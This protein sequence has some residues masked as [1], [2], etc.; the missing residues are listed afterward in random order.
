MLL[1][2]SYISISNQQT[3]ERGRKHALNSTKFIKKEKEMSSGMFQVSDSVLLLSISYPFSFFF[4]QMEKQML[5]KLEAAKFLLRHLYNT[6]NVEGRKRERETNASS[7][8]YDVTRTPPS[9]EH[10]ECYIYNSIHTT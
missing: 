5:H 2:N 8:L 10:Q 7:S 4:F 6:S 9:P 1:E 3:K